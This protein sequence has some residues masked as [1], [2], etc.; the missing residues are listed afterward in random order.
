MKAGAIAAIIVVPSV[1]LVAIL[2]ALYYLYRR[3]RKKIEI[4]AESNSISSLNN[5]SFSIK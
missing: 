3:N 1:V 2:A 5:K 4:T